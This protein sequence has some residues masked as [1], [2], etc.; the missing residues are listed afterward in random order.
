MATPPVS[1]GAISCLSVLIAQMGLPQDAV[2]TGATAIIFLDFFTTSSRILMS[3]LETLL[4]ADRLGML[5]REI[6]LQK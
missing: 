5:N 4:Q 3:H 6:L 1:G 2:A